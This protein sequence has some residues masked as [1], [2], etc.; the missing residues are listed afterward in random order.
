MRRYLFALAG[1]ALAVAAS[2]CDESL[3]SLTGPTPNLE[4]TF[5]SIQ[6][7]IFESTDTAGRVACVNCHNAAGAQFTANLN[8]TRNVAYDQLVNVASVQRR[9]LRRVTPGDPERSY[10]VH[11]IEGRSGIIGRRMPIGG[12]AFLTDGQILVIKR[13]IERGA[14][15]D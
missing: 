6:R 13:W 3:S 9:D 15:R 14:P 7:E 2:A 4:P 12:S 5:T 11:K 8:L 1:A 10:L